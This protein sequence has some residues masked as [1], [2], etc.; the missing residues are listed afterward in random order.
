MKLNKDYEEIGLDLNKNQII[1]MIQKLEELKESDIG[2]Y[3][4]KHFHMKLNKSLGL[5]ISKIK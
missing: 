1:E 5:T 2:D 3:D 4:E